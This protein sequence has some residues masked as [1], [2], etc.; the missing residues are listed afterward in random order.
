MSVAKWTTIVA[1]LHLGGCSD[2]PTSCTDELRATP[3]GTITWSD[4]AARVPD[5]V[6]AYYHGLPTPEDCSFN[7]PTEGP[8]VYSCYEGPPGPATLRVFFQTQHWD[9]SFHVTSDGCHAERMTLDLELDPAQ[10]E[11]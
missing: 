1:C 7:P 11:P 10:G 5:R 9:T 6:Y 2:E 8:V 4:N 3:S